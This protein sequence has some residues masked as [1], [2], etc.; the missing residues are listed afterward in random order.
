VTT[1]CI[2]VTGGATVLSFDS[3]SGRCQP[4]AYCRSDL[5]KRLVVCLATYSA[6]ES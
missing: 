4:L 2:S 6:T 1:Q 3:W 5:P